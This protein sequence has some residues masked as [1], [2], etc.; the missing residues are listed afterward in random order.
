M[1]LLFLLGINPLLFV[2]TLTQNVCISLRRFARGGPLTVILN[3][4]QGNILEVLGT[5][6]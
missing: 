2:P 5:R 1:K 3:D 4:F 6:K